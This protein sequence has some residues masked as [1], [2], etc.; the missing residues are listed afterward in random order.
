MHA[1][2]MQMYRNRV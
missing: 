1:V 2:V